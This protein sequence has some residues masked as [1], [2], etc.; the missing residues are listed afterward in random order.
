MWL[1]NCV[2]FILGF[3]SS[4]LCVFGQ[5]EKADRDGRVRQSAPHK[6]LRVRHTVAGLRAMLEGGC[7]RLTFQIQF[8]DFLDAAYYAD[9]DV[10][11][12]VTGARDNSCCLPLC[13]GN[14]KKTLTLVVP[15]VPGPCFDAATRYPHSWIFRASICTAAQLTV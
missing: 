12:M 3:G 6:P 10:M 1:I 4:L 2:F 5:G 14:P 11:A 13:N 7:E 15:R 9:V 8:D